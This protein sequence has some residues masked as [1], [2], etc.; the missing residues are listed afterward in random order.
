MNSVRNISVTQITWA[1]GLLL[2]LALAI[3]MGSA[4]GSNDFQKVIMIL[5]AGIG[6]ATFLVIGKHYWLLIP[7]SMG[8]KFPAVPFGGRS[9]EFP[10]LAIAACSVFFIL[11]VATRKEKLHLF[12]SINLPI[13]I[14]VAWVSMVFVL[15]PIGL[16]MLGSSTGGG[17]FYVK[18]A[19]AFAAFVILSNRSYSERDIRWVIA[20]LIFGAI[21]GV[22]YGFA[23]YTLVGPAIDPVTG[24]VGDEFYTW[25]Q[26]LSLPAMTIA[27]LVFSR[28]SPREVFGL[29]RPLI[30]L[31]YLGCLALVLLSGKRMGLAAV[32]MAP[33]V[34]ALMFRQMIYI[35]VA[36]ALLFTAVA[37]LVVGQGQW[38]NLPIV[39]QRTLSWLPGNWDSELE[40]LRGGGDDFRTELRRV[41]MESIKRYPIVGRG[42][43]IDLNETITAIGM[44]RYGGDVEIQAAAFALGRSWHNRWLGYAADFGIPLTIIQAIIFLTI[45]ILSFRNFRLLGNSSLLG[46][47]SLYVFIFTCR[48]VIASHT[49][50]H[51]AIDAFERWWMYGII[52]AIYLQCAQR[53]VYRTQSSTPAT[54]RPHNV[55]PSPAPAYSSARVP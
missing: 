26:L 24:M 11:R 7:L 54:G 55:A 41:A 13:L 9:L 27:F 12:R 49:S 8:A 22:V 47:F 51:S 36:L 38:F 3:A 17:R 45:L 2:G 42:F 21:F 40:N 32:L 37:T 30:A 29:Q 10:E 43:S 18:I 34:S 28:W 50:G 46:V 35:P 52:I 19:L 31:I 53:N 20:L 44:G 33:A 4:V 1:I 23:E 14:F 48:D 39:A 6:I 25:H 15:N 16:A 5:G